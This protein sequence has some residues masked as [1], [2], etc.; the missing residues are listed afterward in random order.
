MSGAP[1]NLRPC[2][3]CGKD[4]RH[5]VME[6]T[7]GAVSHRI[8]CRN[9][10]CGALTSCWGTR[11]AARFAWNRRPEPEAGSLMDVAGSWEENNG[12]TGVTT[13]GRNVQ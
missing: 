12:V 10:G 7:D 9:V 8:I 13:N 11:R 6:D 2:P 4:A 3:F 1:Q 5:V